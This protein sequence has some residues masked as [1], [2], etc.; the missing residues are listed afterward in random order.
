M[1]MNQARFG[2][3]AIF[4]GCLLL[5]LGALFLTRN[6]MWPDDFLAVMLKLVS[7][8]S[9]QLGVVFGGIFAQP[10]PPLADPPAGLAWTAVALAAMWNLLLIWRTVSFGFAE[11][12]SPAALIK[13]LDSVASASSFLVAGV[14]AFFFGK[15][16]EPNTSPS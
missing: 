11:Q 16:T 9:V 6:K 10:R 7:I 8:Y 14:I 5:Q 3:I 2:L 13:Y 12:D 4:L 15:G 1:S